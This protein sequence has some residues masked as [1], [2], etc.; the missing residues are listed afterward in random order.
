[1]EFAIATT[2]DDLLS[3]NAQEMAEGYSF[4][5][6]CNIPVN[7]HTITRSQA[8]GIMAAKLD[9]GLI[10]NKALENVLQDYWDYMTSVRH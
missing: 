5:M 4:A 9:L 8:H 1:M 6:S 7:D 10:T 3:L 2:L